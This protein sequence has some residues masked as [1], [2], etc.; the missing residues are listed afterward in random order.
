MPK[1]VYN[2]TFTS[3]PEQLRCNGAI[4]LKSRFN[5]KN[6][7]IKPG[8]KIFVSV[9]DVSIVFD[10]ENQEYAKDSFVDVKFD[11]VRADCDSFI[12]TTPSI[13]RFYCKNYGKCFE[14]FENP[15]WFEFTEE[16]F[17][18]LH[19]CKLEF[20][21]NRKELVTFNYLVPHAEL[22]LLFMISSPTKKRRMVLR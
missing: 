4:T 12:Y 14:R 1:N 7:R 19:C 20:S 22:T 10:H 6:L 2:V 11:G 13:G 9:R 3:N 16:M 5:P 18:S 8:D 15:I 17:D 21:I